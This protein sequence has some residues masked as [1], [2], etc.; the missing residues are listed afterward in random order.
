LDISASPDTKIGSLEGSGN[1]LLGD[2]TLTVG[3][4]G[5]IG[6]SPVFSGVIQDG[7]GGSVGSLAIQN[8]NL[9]LTGSNTYA[10]TTTVGALGTLTVDNNGTTTFGS[11]GAGAVTIDN[12]GLVDG[13]EGILNFTSA[14]TAGSGTFTN[15]GATV[16]NTWNGGITE[17]SGTST[18][19]NATI[20]NNG[21]NG[22]LAGGGS[23]SFLGNSTAGS[24]TLIA[25]SGANGGY[26]GGIYFSN[27]ADGGTARVIANGN[28]VLDISGLSKSGMNI[29]SIE[30]S[31]IFSLGSKSLTVGG[32]NVSAVVSGKIQDGGING[33]TGGSLIKTGNGVL[34]L[35]GVNGYTGSTTVSQGTLVV[36]GSI[37]SSSVVSVSQGATLGGAG[38]VSKISGAGLVAP[39]GSQILTATQ[40]DPGSGMS[41]DF[42]FSQLGGPT[43][44][45]ASASGNDVLH[46]TGATPLL[47]PLT[48][49]NTIDVDFSAITNSLASGQIYYGGF[50]LDAAAAVGNP[51]FDFTGNG[52]EAVHYL[53]L[54]P[55]ASASF[56][57][58]TVTNGHVMAFMVTA[59]LTKTTQTTTV[60]AGANYNTIA[61]VTAT[62]GFG[63]KA[64]IASGLASAPSNVTVAFNGAGDF[65][66]I[67]SDV[68]TVSGMP[69]KGTG[70]QGSTLTDQFVLELGYNV[71]AANALGGAS[72]LTLMWNSPT[73][74]WVNAILGNSDGGAGANFV[75]GAY[76]AGSDF[77]LSW[78]GVDVADG[79][80][81]AVLD[82]NSDYGAG[83][84]SNTP[85][86]VVPEPSTWTMLAIGGTG[87]LFF[88]RRAKA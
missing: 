24:A 87:L 9:T 42:Q 4:N 38:L 7:G 77:N 57:S 61:P 34:T 66:N 27:Q 12:G 65:G 3:G 44:N 85:F 39:G 8:G 29:G 79:Y 19:G 82:H 17:F 71:T 16:N 67:A 60:S 30:G 75:A 10:G 88:L 64:A 40:V 63:S 26:G 2:G 14:A 54:A 62:G 21:G 50:F 73:A 13:G 53:G 68:A 22:G 52:T 78:Y 6:N 69:N 5:R 55:V 51:A 74:G 80:V 37:A 70:P 20:T 35:N 47:S 36:N 31:G 58:G 18:A 46:L 25:N 45:N 32:N 43:Y 11:L 81:W 49:A 33:G 28:G 56:T 59:P 72:A 15:N 76:I 86:G 1:V 48:S 84:L 83:N 23:V 41:F